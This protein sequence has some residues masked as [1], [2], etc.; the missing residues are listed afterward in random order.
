MSDEPGYYFAR[1]QAVQK[2][3]A[4]LIRI[5]FGG[6]DLGRYASIGVPD[7]SVA[8][9]FPNRG[10]ARPEPMECRDGTW[11][12][13]KC[14]TPPVGRNYTVRTFDVASGEMTIDF[15]AHVGGVAAQWAINAEIGS[16][17]L[18]TRPRSWYCPPDGTQ[19]Q[20]IVADLTGLPAAARIVESIDPDTT[21]HMIVEVID[22][23][24]LNALPSAPNVVLDIS[25]GTGNG[26]GPSVL[27]DRV[28]K[29]VPASPEGYLWF[30]GEAGE[31]RLVRKH[32]RSKFGWDASRYDTIGYWRVDAERWLK[33]Y[34][35]VQD[36]VLGVYQ[37]ALDDGRSLKEAAEALDSELERVG[38]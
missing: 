21:V 3:S 14:D 34:K 27:S 22:E 6:V 1:V 23:T 37:Q 4:N 19:W 17:L 16:E 15:V 35:E 2:L 10:Q 12:F 11:G 38:L 31:S 36:T 33:S 25:V 24:D 30:A 28:R 7:E 8:L 20:L 18:M 9:Y 26:I 29:F 13:Y 32:A 5:V